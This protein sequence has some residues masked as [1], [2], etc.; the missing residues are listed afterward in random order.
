MYVYVKYK[1]KANPCYDLDR[2]FL[3]NQAKKVQSVVQKGGEGEGEGEGKGR[4]EGMVCARS[5]V[6]WVDGQQHKVIK[7]DQSTL[8]MSPLVLYC[9]YC[10][11]VLYIPLTLD[12]GNVNGK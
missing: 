4:K 6:W 3:S 9:S 1:A 5:V 8:L 12:A 10:S 11:T 2:V 7:V